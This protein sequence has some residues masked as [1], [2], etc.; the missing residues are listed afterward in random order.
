MSFD[1]PSHQQRLVKV[2][3]PADYPLTLFVINPINRHLVRPLF[4]LGVSPT[5]IT[6]LSFI[7]GCA[8]MYALMGA[9]AEEL[10]Y[11]YLAPIL[12]FLEH[13]LDCLDGDLARY[14]QR[15]SQFGAALD[16]MLDRA[17]E[18]GYVFAVA[19]GLSQVASTDVASVWKIWAAAMLCVGGNQIY[20]YATDAQISRIA[21]LAA[22][23]LER[24]SFVTDSS[25]QNTKIKLGLYEPY[26][27]GLA[28][29][30]SLG[31]GFE[32]LVL[33]ACV[34]WAAWVGQIWK[35][36]RIT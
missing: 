27:Y 25:I 7:V 3:R 8:G 23:D 28:I 32:A 18:F 36:H 26:K 33:F 22:H 12:V 35:L 6:L 2:R 15:S 34:F 19:F 31:H 17:V 21:H 13:L 20:F 30:T 10:V 14:S 5:T 24:F 16:P 4:R 1:L 9:A 29:A 11:L